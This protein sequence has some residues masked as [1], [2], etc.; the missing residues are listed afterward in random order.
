MRGGRPKLADAARCFLAM[1]VVA[2]ISLSACAGAEDSEITREQAIELARPH[3]D[4]EP[5]TVEAKKD[6]DNGRPVWR[7]IFRGEPGPHP[8]GSYQEIVIDRR[9]GEVVGLAQS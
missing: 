5:A 6:T 1:L 7:V 2:C 4:F 9:S 3:V 8:M